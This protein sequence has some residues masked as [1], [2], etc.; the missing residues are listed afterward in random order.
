MLPILR[1]KQNLPSE[2]FG[3]GNVFDMFEDEFNRFFGSSVY[4]DEQGNY[5]YE[6]EVPGFNKENIQVEASDG[7]ITISGERKI[8]ENNHAGRTKVF[9]QL[10]IG[11][12]PEDVSAKIVDGILS[13]T[14]TNREKENKTKKIEVNDESMIE[15]EEI[16]S[17]DVG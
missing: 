4:K 3:I 17:V 12:A 9:K 15:D 16:K 8:D 14:F 10:N 5:V 13:L 1:N 6:M 11:C 2:C 7:I